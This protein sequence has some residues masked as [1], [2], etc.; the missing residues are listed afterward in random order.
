MSLFKETKPVPVVILDLNAIL[1]SNIQLQL[2]LSEVELLCSHG[3]NQT[4]WKVVGN[5]KEIVTGPAHVPATRERVAMFNMATISKCEINLNVGT[6]LQ[7][8]KLH[9]ASMLQY[10]DLLSL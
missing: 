7:N 1:I 8:R 6:R 9:K 2:L 3:N 4:I 10:H 5:V